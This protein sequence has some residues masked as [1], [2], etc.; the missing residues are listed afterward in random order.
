MAQTTL[1]L[2]FR[3]EREQW[4]TKEEC[5]A[6]DINVDNNMKPMIRGV[7]TKIRNIRNIEPSK[8]NESVMISRPITCFGYYTL[9]F[10]EHKEA[11]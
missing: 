8:K 11:N 9:I 10:V 5:T 6:A 1:S 2:S 7:I 4:Q 3:E